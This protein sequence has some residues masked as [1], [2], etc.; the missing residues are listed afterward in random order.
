MTTR[1]DWYGHHYDVP[2][3]K[4]KHMKI[5]KTCSICGKQL[6]NSSIKDKH[7]Q[8]HFQHTTVPPYIGNKDLWL[9]RIGPDRTIP[10]N[11]YIRFKES[12]T[13]NGEGLWDKDSRNK[14][15]IGDKLG[16]IV[17]QKDNEMIDM[18]SVINTKSKS[19]RHDEWNVDIPYN[20]LSAPEP[21]TREVI[22][23]KKDNCKY[24]D[25]DG[26]VKTGIANWQMY[27]SIVGYKSFSI[28]VQRSFDIPPK[29]IQS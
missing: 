8:K 10:C 12:I 9:C 29:M 20:E 25:S 1:N 3:T 11:D 14:I 26:V 13:K 22:V 17:G 24:V 4:L 27:K 7:E 2:V 16:F 19:E 18:Y 21:K 28:R 15:N 6:S 23:L 5:S